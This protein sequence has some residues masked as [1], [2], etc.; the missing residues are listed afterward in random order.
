[1]T[2]ASLNL[3]LRLLN[4]LV[5]E[6]E[7]ATPPDAE[8]ARLHPTHVAGAINLRHYLTLRRYDLRKLQRELA[9]LGLSSLGRAEGHVQATLLAVR[10]ALSLLA[11]AGTAPSEPHRGPDFEA[12]RSR[13]A[14]NA[15]MLF[16]AP[17][18]G[19]GVGIMVTA[20]RGMAEEPARIRRLLERGM[21]VLRINCAHDE[22][23][24]WVKIADH[25]RAAERMS[26]TPCRLLMD[27]GGPKIRTGALTLGPAMQTW[28][29]HRD[30]RGQVARPAEVW[31]VPEGEKSPGPGAVLHFPRAWLE[32][33]AVGERIEFLDTRA[34]KRHLII[35][36]REG[37]ALLAHAE[38]RA[39]VGVL[40][41]FRR[42]KQQREP[43]TALDLPREEV[44]IMLAVGEKLVLTRSLAPG[45]AERRDE[46][47]LQVEPGYVGCS[48]PA[49]F[50]RVRR[51]QRVLLDDGKFE[52]EVVGVHPDRLE[53][54][55]VRGQGKLLSEKG[56]NVPDT[57]LDLPGL[58]AEDKI[59]LQT[60]VRLADL[61]GLSF[62]QSAGDIRALRAELASLGA[63][64][65]GLIL[66][67]ETVNA[68]AAMPELLWAAMEHE[69]IGVMIAR[70]DLAVE[71]GYQRLAEVQEELLWISEAAHVP[72]IWAT[73][74]LEGLAK[75]G[76]PTRAEVTDA[77]MGSRAECVM[78]NK[79]PHIEEA[80]SA[81]D[82]I[83]RRM[84]EH[85]SKK[86]PQLRALRSWRMS[87]TNDQVH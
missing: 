55:V 70:G 49:L 16:G 24:T 64:H 71:C 18:A 10:R 22:P 48:E 66:K 58:T 52:T 51:G 44:A 28:K 5:L 32:S 50:E 41:P 80:V 19:R 38:R 53:L 33:I 79:G 76:L 23:A 81:L 62:V 82:D 7:K 21:N 11:G 1:V 8:L 86:T 74:V 63:Q 14:E 3:T 57:T 60:V 39:F 87:A 42:G 4:D 83:L 40:T 67:I 68:F 45:R 84:D 73:Q 2:N 25:L 65:L 12:G 77:A 47:G 85:Q 30:A 35:H 75:D 13:L 34:R 31:L 59:H 78:L 29:V 20:D 26:S 17:P 6:T 46:S 27:L 15:A 36:R 69:R 43:V 72:T 54:R 56:I 9:E 61:V 37:A